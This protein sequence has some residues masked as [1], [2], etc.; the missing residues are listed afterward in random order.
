MEAADHHRKARGAELARE[1]ERVR[2]LV[3]LDSHQPDQ[4]PGAAPLDVAGDARRNDM[5]VALVDRMEVEADV[6]PQHAAFGGIAGEAVQRGERV[7]GQ[8]RP[9]PDDR[10]AVVVI[11]RRLDHVE[12]ELFGALHHDFVD[13]PICAGGV[14]G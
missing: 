3:G 1:V 2:E 7:G 5:L 12:I 4:R 10:I 14:V 9:P 8:D 6:R 13:T 11:M